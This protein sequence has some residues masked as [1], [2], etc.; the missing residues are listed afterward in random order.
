MDLSVFMYDPVLNLVLPFKSTKGN[1]ALA[2]LF[3]KV[4][5]I[6]SFG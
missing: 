6:S 1:E 5:M 4:D 3:V 2:C